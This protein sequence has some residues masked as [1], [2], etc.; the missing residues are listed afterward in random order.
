MV[1]IYDMQIRYRHI[2]TASKSHM[3]TNLFQKKYLARKGFKVFHSLYYYE[4]H[5]PSSPAGRLPREIID[6]IYPTI[7]YRC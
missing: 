6:P 7:F 3:F 5:L 2:S 1:A 4:T